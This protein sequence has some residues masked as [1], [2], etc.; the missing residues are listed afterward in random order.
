MKAFLWALYL[1]DYPDAT[2]EVPVDDRYKPDVVQTDRWG[3][4]VF[5]AEA[6]RVGK[7]KIERLVRRYRD[8][9]FAMAKWDTDIGPFREI[10]AE[11][12]TDLDRSAPFDLIHFP[13]DSVDRFVDE[14]GTI[15]L[16]ADDLDR[17]RIS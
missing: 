6:G 4:P 12:V 17:T 14:R 8:T 5:W 7:E 3:E 10:V 13:P 11:A 16:T 9:H 2:I 15:H 1:P